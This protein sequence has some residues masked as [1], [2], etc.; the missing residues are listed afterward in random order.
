MKNYQGGGTNV[1]L[2]RGA[3][4]SP[5]DADGAAVMLLM[6]GMLSEICDPGAEATPSSS[7]ES[8]AAVWPWATPFMYCTRTAQAGSTCVRYV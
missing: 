2:V 1:N 4:I 5:A 3:I 8:S 6:S 7:G